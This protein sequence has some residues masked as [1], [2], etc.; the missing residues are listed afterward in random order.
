M[1][2]AE[3]RQLVDCAPFAADHRRLWLSLID[4]VEAL[5]DAIVGAQ[6]SDRGAL[7]EQGRRRFDELRAICG[8]LEIDPRLVGTMADPVGV[9]VRTIRANLDEHRDTENVVEQQAEQLR[10][11]AEIVSGGPPPD[12]ET[13]DLSDVAGQVR[14]M[15]RAAVELTDDLRATAER[16]RAERDHVVITLLEQLARP[17]AVIDEG[18]TR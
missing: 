18:G 7:V 17:T 14:S 15:Q 6:P 4:H 12:G 9:I 13:H 16:F 8:A 2:P 11:I 5:R 1:T 10:T 3:M